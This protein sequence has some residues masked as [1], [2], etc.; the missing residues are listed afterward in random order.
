M[1]KKHVAFSGK[2]LMIG[3]GSIGQAT[4][5]PLFEVMDI[6]PEQITILTADDRGQAVAKEYGINFVVKALSRENYKT[7][8]PTYVDKGDLIINLSVDT[9]S[10]DLMELCNQLGVLYVDTVVE[11][12]AG[13]GGY[14]DKCGTPL[15]HA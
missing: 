9:S 1:D 14:A 6:K 3:F 13:A 10:V 11:P 4:L 15:W 12:W 2:V 5:A 7:L 8:I